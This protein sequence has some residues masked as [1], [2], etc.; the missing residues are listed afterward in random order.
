MRGTV[1]FFD[2]RRGFGMINPEDGSQAVFVHFTAIVGEPK[3]L[4]ETEPVEFDAEPQPDKGPKA[5]QVKRLETR[6]KG[7]VVAFEKGYGRLE[8]E[9]GGEST[10]VH[11]TDILGDGFK[12]L[13]VDEVVDYTRVMG[14]KG[15]KAIR[16]K[17][18]TRPPL[19]KFAVIS[20]LDQKLE[21]LAVLAQKENWEYRHATSTYKRP[22]LRS[23]LYYTFP[24][25]QAEGK[26]AEAKTKDGPLACFNT[27]LVTERQEPIFALLTEFKNP[28]AGDPA[29]ILKGFHR[30][31][32]R[33]LTHF[34]QRPDIANYFVDPSE[35]LY[36][37]RIE[38]VVDVDHVTGDNKERFPVQLRDNEYA[39][40]GALDGAISAAKRRIRRNYK[41]AIPHFYRGRLQLLLPL[42]MVAP[43]RADLALVVGRENEVYRAATVLTL[44]MAY[45]NARLIARPDTEWLDP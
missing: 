19:E 25:L 40:R 17:R 31:S 13:E 39:L 20:D 43:E 45:N 11:H 5:V 24:R 37:T 10:F 21:Q 42:C 38:L 41:T 3:V 44:D 6:L 7:K 32:D 22:I 12:T 2:E 15:P 4:V 26:I 16:V 30:E 14:P 18:D 35:L 9:G 1:K 36:D 23:Y 27:G 8:P 28:S 29:W 33:P 34:G